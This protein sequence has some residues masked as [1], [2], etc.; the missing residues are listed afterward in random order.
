MAH[1]RRFS[2][3]L[4][5]QVVRAELPGV[6]RITVDDV[7]ARFEWRD[8][9]GVLRIALGSGEPVVE[10]RAREYLTGLVVVEFTGSSRGRFRPH[11]VDFPHEPGGEREEYERVLRCAVRFGRPDLEIVVAE[12][13]LE[14]RLGTARLGMS[15]RTLQRRLE[16]EDSSF[17]AAWDQVRRARAQERLEDPSVSIS[18]LAD[19]LG[20]ASVAAFSKAF[21][22]WTGSAPSTKRKRSRA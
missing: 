13:M 5:Q 20:F 21:R 4:V 17:R 7:D 8:S 16:D 10:R 1:E 22:R 11:R 15:V 14:T 9:L 18:Q 6:P 12:D 3:H 19:E 2:E